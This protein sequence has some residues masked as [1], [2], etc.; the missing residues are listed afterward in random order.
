LLAEGAV[1][2]SKD[3]APAAVQT[4]MA[5]VIDPFV[6]WEW[7]IDPNHF[8]L[9]PTANG[10]CPAARMPLSGL[11]VDDTPVPADLHGLAA[12][13]LLGCDELD[14]AVAMPVIV[15]VDERGHPVWRRLDRAS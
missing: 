10:A 8:W 11:F 3:D 7:W 15:P 2:A 4:A 9:R 1:A 5:N 13:A 12:V 14:A 6:F